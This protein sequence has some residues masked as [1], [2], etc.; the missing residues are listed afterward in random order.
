MKFSDL[1]IGPR[2]YAGFAL[3]VAILIALVTTSYMNFNS[4]ETANRMNVHTY[5]VMAEANAM[6]ESLINIETGQRGFSLTG[7]EGSL[8]PLTAGTQAFARHLAKARSLTADNPGQQQRLAQLEQAQAQW[9]HAAID[10]AL[11]LRRGVAA[12]TA[13][14]DN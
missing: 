3:I 12:G 1:N 9:M 6:L 7:K 5:E 10:P 4:L 13:T 11:A 2:L 14:L 8:E